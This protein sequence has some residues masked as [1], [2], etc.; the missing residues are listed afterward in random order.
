MVQA[1]SYG[2]KNL[3]FALLIITAYL[4]TKKNKKIKIKKLKKGRKKMFIFTL[5]SAHFYLWLYVVCC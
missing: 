3:I 5:Y 2:M 1:I 4:F